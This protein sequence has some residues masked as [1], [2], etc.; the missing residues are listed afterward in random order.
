MEGVSEEGVSEGVSCFQGE[1]G[2]PTV[3]R[4]SWSLPSLKRMPASFC[5]QGRSMP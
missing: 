5:H 4:A 2:G 3:S 1:V